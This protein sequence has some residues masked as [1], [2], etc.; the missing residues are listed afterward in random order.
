MKNLEEDHA[1]LIVA[2]RQDEYAARRDTTATRTILIIDDDLDILD[3]LAWT[4]EEEG[5]TVAAVTNGREALQWIQAAAAVGELP[6]LIL[7]DLAMPIMSGSQVVEAMR[8]LWGGNVPPIVVISADCF[9]HRH[10][11]ELGAVFTLTKPFET[12]RLLALVR[13]FAG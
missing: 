6:V 2:E 11:R 5:Y 8:Q 12:E 3:A 10:A 13:Q 9:A 1:K 4:L 7:L